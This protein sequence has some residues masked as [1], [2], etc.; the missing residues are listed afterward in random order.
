M[1][2]KNRTLLWDLVQDENAVSVGLCN[3]TEI[4]LLSFYLLVLLAG[5]HGTNDSA[6]WPIQVQSDASITETVFWYYSRFIETA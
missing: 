2:R 5:L 6:L 3:E 4:F 1:C